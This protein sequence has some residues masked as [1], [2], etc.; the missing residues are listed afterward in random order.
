MLRLNDVIS[1]GAGTTRCSP[2]PAP[3]PRFAPLG[4]EEGQP[5]LVSASLSPC[6]CGCLQ[7]KHLGETWELGEGGPVLW[8]P[9]QL[10]HGQR[11]SQNFPGAPK[12]HPH[13]C[14]GTWQL[15]GTSQHSLPRFFQ[16]G[17]KPLNPCIKILLPETRRAASAFLTS[18]W[19]QLK[20][21]TILV[22]NFARQGFYSRKGNWR[23]N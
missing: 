12:N 8:G 19:Q 2:D 5:F 15:V 16:Q 4:G 20:A 10:K 17:R 21:A 18:P 6:G 7:D 13:Q 14:V 1:Q 3:P 9:L 11:G 22:I 23:A